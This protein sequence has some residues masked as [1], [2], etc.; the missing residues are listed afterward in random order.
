MYFKTSTETD[1]IKAIPAVCL[2]GALG[3]IFLV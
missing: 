2:N 1:S 3:G